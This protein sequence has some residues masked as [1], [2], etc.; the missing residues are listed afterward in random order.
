[1]RAAARAWYA[2]EVRSLLELAQAAVARGDAIAAIEAALEAWRARRARRLGDLVVALEAWGTPEGVRRP[3][4]GRDALEAMVALAP[5]PRASRAVT[6]VL[7][8]LRGGVELWLAAIAAIERLDDPALLELAAAPAS[9]PLDAVTRAR[10]AA[11]LD[12]AMQRL[13][14][15]FPAG[16]PELDPDCE[17]LCAAIERRLAPAASAQRAAATEAELL[18]AIYAHPADD[19][20]RRVYADWLLERGD[21]RGELIQLELA[22]A[23]DDAAE[24]RHA[25]L[26]A[27]AQRQWLGPLAEVLRAPRFRRGFVAAAQVVWDNPGQL[28]RLGSHPAWATLEEIDYGASSAS[29]GS[30]RQ[31]QHLDAAMRGLRR[32]RGVSDAGVLNLCAAAVPW[33]L[34]ELRVE[35][36]DAEAARALA[37]TLL[38]PAL[39][40]LRLICDAPLSWLW[41]ARWAQQI[42][43]LSIATRR[44]IWTI[45]RE[46]SRWR[47]LER[48]EVLHGEGRF[49]L[50]RGPEHDFSL[51]RTEVAPGALV[52]LLERAPPDALTGLEHPG[53]EPRAALGPAWQARLEAALRRQRRL[54]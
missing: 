18:D 19:D 46:A 15:R 44:Q 32:L 37:T 31:W 50:S 5:D 54:S 10:M 26:E 34:A 3:I 25:E 23:R 4:D 22:A 13:R 49:E 8:E 2:C 28:E 51:L 11:R 7:G 24:A 39:R 48:L 9:W 41:H 53:L 40:E 20:A 42:E 27:V 43:R 6:L 35:V 36:R 33:A 17:A 30:A 47:K 29:W 38:L 1:M 12:T 14:R 52:K 21:A 16:A 45:R